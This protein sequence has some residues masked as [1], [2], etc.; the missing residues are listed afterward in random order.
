MSRNN[1]KI[2]NTSGPDEH[3]ETLGE[4]LNQLRTHLT[5]AAAGKGTWGDYLRLLEFYR[6]TRDTSASEIIVRWVDNEDRDVID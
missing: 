6:E 3:I 1:R 5:G 2:S 4:L